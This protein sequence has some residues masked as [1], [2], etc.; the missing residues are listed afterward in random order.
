MG[1]TTIQNVI[2][3]SLFCPL[4]SQIR[5]S[6]LE[7][8]ARRVGGLN[9][10]DTPDIFD[11]QNTLSNCH[12]TQH[13]LNISGFQIP[14]TSGN[15]PLFG[16]VFNIRQGINSEDITAILNFKK[17][18]TRF[19]RKMFLIL[20]HCEE[21]TEN[22]R[23]ELIEEF[24]NHSRFM[25]NHVRQFFERGVLCMGCIRRE[26]LE[27]GNRKALNFEHN[28]VLQMRA[29]F[30]RRCQDNDRGGWMNEDDDEIQFNDMIAEVKRWSAS[31]NKYPFRQT[32]TH[33]LLLMG[34]T[35]TGKTTVANVLADPCYVPPDAKLHSE[36]R[37]VSVHPVAATMIREN[38]VYC[39]NV[40]DTPGLYDKVTKSGTPMTNDRIKAAIDECIKKDVTNMHLF[41]FVISLQSNVDVDDINS[42]VFVRDN[43]PKLH[44]F[45][46]LLVTHCEE[47]T[48]EQRE[49]KVNEFFDSQ[50]VVNHK[51]KEFF[52]QKIFYMGALRP[53][54]KTHPNKQSVR[55]QIRN[56]HKMRETFLEYI[57]ALDVKD[58]FNIHRVDMQGGCTLL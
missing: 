37:E 33:N 30:I 6:T 24:F 13:G 9:I 53:E 49:A 46:C 39:F 47:S 11:N 31:K 54:L 57:I 18:F 2:N 3:D 34:K 10:I 20:T 1:K 22:Q 56:V 16:F 27:S 17:K 42:M 28:Q 45:I 58:S 12:M 5:N 29:E 23:L 15:L 35:R 40:V 4:Q 52:A 38:I 43:Y 41:A 21:K 51:L 36:T 26:S 32:I 55:Q 48:T 19:S 7:P 8:F 25:N 14:F 44:Q 50:E